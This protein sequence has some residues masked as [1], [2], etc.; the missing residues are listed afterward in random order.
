MLYRGVM[1]TD[2]SGKIDG[3]VASHNRGGPYFRDHVIPVDPETARQVNCRETL[4]DL[5]D[6]WVNEVTE[7][8]RQAWTRYAASRTRSSRIGT[9]RRLIGWTE[10]CRQ[11]Y[12]AF[13]S[14][15]QLGTSFFPVGNPPH[16]PPNYGETPYCTFFGTTQIDLWFSNGY[17]WTLNSNS[18]ML[19]YVSQQIALTRN[20]YKGPYQL[21]GEVHGNDGDPPVAPARFDLPYELSPDRR[22]FYRVCYFSEN[23]QRAG[24][25]PNSLLTP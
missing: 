12:W 1:I 15:Q 23:E 25:F 3:A 11:H 24:P 21:I 20:F 7:P 19:L 14:N 5:W 9:K 17:P 22:V 2:L 16:E 6:A 13:Q 18:G 4:M 10:Y 8:Q